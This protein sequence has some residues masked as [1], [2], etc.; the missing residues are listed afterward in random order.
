[1]DTTVWFRLLGHGVGIVSFHKRSD[2]DLFISKLSSE[3][4]EYKIAN[5]KFTMD[6]FPFKGCL[7]YKGANCDF[8]L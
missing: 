3:L 2:A 5:G 6:D 7:S 1:M 8:Y 4:V